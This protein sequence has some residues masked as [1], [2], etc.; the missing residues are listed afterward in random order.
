MNHV[1]INFHDIVNHCS[2]WDDVSFEGMSSFLRDLKALVSEHKGYESPKIFLTF[3]DGYQSVIR[4]LDK[5]V[6]SDWK[7]VFVFPICIHLGKAGYL[8]VDDLRRLQH[9]GVKI[10]S[11]GQ[12]HLDYS[13]ASIQEQ[14]SDASI[15]KRT[16]E[17]I[18][19]ASVN[20]FSLPY[21]ACGHNTVQTL[22]SAGYKRVYGSIRG[23]VVERE[24]V[25]R[26]NAVNQHLLRL[27]IDQFL[28]ISLVGN[29]FCKVFNVMSMLKNNRALKGAYES[30]RVNQNVRK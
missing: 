4:L 6:F 5:G 26:R 30:F 25:I 17:D 28:P 9:F 23:K 14:Y 12:A 10:G 8:T 19:G 16:L 15:A 27:R 21:G 20:D 3:D 2:Q 22:E 1:Y 29:S 11:H 18:L 7:E 13:K 24:R